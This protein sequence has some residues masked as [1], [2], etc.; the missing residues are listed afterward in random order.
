MPV[1]D[2]AMAL[3]TREY[4]QIEY[5]GRQQSATATIHYYYGMYRPLEDLHAVNQIAG[6]N[7]VLVFH[8]GLHFGAT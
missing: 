1:A 5:D 6:D 3:W 7:D 4:V 8:H 2:A